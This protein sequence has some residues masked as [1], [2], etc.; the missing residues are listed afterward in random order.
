M[1]D[2]SFSFCTPQQK[3]NDKKESIG[4]NVN[5]LNNNIKRFNRNLFLKPILFSS[6]RQEQN[7]DIYKDIFRDKYK[8]FDC[9][10]R[11]QTI[12]NLLNIQN[13]ENFEQLKLIQEKE[14]TK[15]KNNSYKSLSNWI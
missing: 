4:N 12:N 10:K 1:L 9:K 15:D 14:R 8:L 2:C 3:H 11:S 6:S 13:A 5:I 7:K